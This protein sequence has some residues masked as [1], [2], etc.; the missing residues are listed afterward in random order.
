MMLRSLYTVIAAMAIVLL[1]ACSADR[2]Y[3]SGQGWQRNQCNRLPDKTDFDRCVARAS[4]PYESYQRSTE[5]N[6]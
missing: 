4:T 1:S 6:H 5:V 3:R 2:L